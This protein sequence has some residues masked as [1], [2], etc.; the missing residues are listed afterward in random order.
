M[1][2]IL[3]FNV[4]GKPVGE[5]CMTPGRVGMIAD[6]P[7]NPLF[8]FPMVAVACFDG[9]AGGPPSASGNGFFGTAMSTDGT[10]GAERHAHVLNVPG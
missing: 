1:P 4:A 2:F 8:R 5:S 10:W 9:P 3:K 6:M 7:L